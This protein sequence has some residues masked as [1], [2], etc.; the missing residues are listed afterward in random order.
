MCGLTKDCQLSLFWYML[1]S[2]F[3]LGTIFTQT[4][5]TNPL[6]HYQPLSPLYRTI[7][8]RHCWGH[9]KFTR[10]KKRPWGGK[11]VKGY[12]HLSPIPTEK[13][14]DLHRANYNSN[15]VGQQ[16]RWSSESERMGLLN[17]NLAS[18]TVKTHTQGR[19]V[20]YVHLKPENKKSLEG[21]VS[22]WQHQ[23]CVCVSKL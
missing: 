4:L 3:A 16:Q 17:S 12:S 5:Q 23:V 9:G 14:S 18:L 6:T 20:L 22:Y 7:L 21:T 11:G 1:W 19:K 13:C 8:S 2:N 15:S 10:S